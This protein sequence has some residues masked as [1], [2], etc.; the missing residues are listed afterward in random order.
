MVLYEYPFNEG[1]LVSNRGLNIPIGEFYNHF[2][3]RQVE[4]ST[5]LHSVIKAR[6]AYFVGPQARYSLNFDRLTPRAQAAAKAASNSRTA[7]P[8]MKSPR[9][10]TRAIAASISSFWSR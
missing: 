2:E 1:A 3:E 6:G 4:H 5:S 10:T 7:A 8:L 9:A